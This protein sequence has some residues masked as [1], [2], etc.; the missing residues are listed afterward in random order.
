VFLKNTHFDHFLILTF[1]KRAICTHI[2]TGFWSGLRA[3]C[4]FKKSH[5]PAGGGDYEVV[6]TSVLLLSSRSLLIL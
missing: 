2:I 3:I 4:I 5:D 1:I 6:H